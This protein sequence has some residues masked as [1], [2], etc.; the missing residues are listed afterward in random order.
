[1]MLFVPSLVGPEE[2]SRSINVN[3]FSTGSSVSAKECLP[4]CRPM[5]P[6][7]RAPSFFYD[8]YKNNLPESTISTE[9]ADSND[10]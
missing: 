9:N 1:M 6:F 10:L 2:P 5:G 7:R 3:S 4:F 8:H